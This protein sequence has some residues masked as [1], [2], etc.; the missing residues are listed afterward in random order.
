MAR[1]ARRH[2]ES[3]FTDVHAAT[4]DLLSEVR[5]TVRSAL[6]TSEIAG[7]DDLID[8]DLFALVASGEIDTA[9]RRLLTGLGIGPSGEEPADFE[10]TST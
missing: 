5:D 1:W 8:D 4:L 10:R 7:W 6:G 9:R 3:M 2:L